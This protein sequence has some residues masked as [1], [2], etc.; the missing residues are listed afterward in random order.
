MNI[1]NGELLDAI[2]PAVEELAK[3][4]N[5]TL[6]LK[7][8]TMLRIIRPHAQDIMELRN[9]LLERFGRKDEDGKLI[10]VERRGQD[11]DGRPVIVNEVQF[12]ASDEESDE[13]GNQAKFIAGQT[14]LLNGEWNYTGPQITV[15][16]LG[17]T[18]V[19]GELLAALGDLFRD[20][21]DEQPAQK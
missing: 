2:L 4:H 5:L 1:K 13:M 11:R 15:K 12:E 16:D 9:G 20:G 17:D 10:T 18:Q 8:R 19:T 3:E 14:E 6:A 21:A 7:T